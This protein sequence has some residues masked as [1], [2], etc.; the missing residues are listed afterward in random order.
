MGISV[1][2]RSFHRRAAITH[3]FYGGQLKAVQCFT[4]KGGGGAPQNRVRLRGSTTP[5]G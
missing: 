5:P 3:I 4:G 1:F 2:L